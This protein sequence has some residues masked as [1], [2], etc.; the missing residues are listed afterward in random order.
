MGRAFFLSPCLQQMKFMAAQQSCAVA[1]ESCASGHYITTS[2][3][4]RLIG[5]LGREV[6]LI[7]PAYVTPF[8]K[9]HKVGWLPPSAYG[10][11]MSH[12]RRRQT[13]ASLRPSIRRVCPQEPVSLLP[14]TISHPA[15]RQFRPA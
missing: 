13:T 3:G 12:G 11:A 1:M 9:R 5:D 4:G 8:V 10:I 14:K 6:R 7:S 2:L 15:K